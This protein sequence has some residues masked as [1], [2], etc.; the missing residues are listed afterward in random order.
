MGAVLS[1]GVERGAFGDIIASDEHWQ[2][3]VQR[4]LSDYLIEQVTSIGKAKVRLEKTGI[5][6]GPGTARR[7]A[8]TRHHGRF[9]TFGC[10]GGGQ[11]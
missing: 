10:R 8:R 9:L 4:Q 6:R 11:F 3:I 5:A 7:L 1:T 2:I